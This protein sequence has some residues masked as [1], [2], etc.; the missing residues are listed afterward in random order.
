MSIFSALICFYCSVG[1]IANVFAQ[2]SRFSN[3]RKEVNY[4][5]VAFG[6]FATSCFLSDFCFKVFK[7]ADMNHGLT[8]ILL[9]V[10]TFVVFAGHLPRKID[11]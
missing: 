8:V 10:S 3:G 6:L 2:A 7:N 9:L 11:R 4:L 5:S 1:A